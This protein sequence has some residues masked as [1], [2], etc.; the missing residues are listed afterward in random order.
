[1]TQDEDLKATRVASKGIKDSKSSLNIAGSTIITL[2]ACSLQTSF[3]DCQHFS[4]S[5]FLSQIVVVM[6]LV[7]TKNTTP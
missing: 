2:S 3:K 6:I 5:E 7:K 4:S 1:M